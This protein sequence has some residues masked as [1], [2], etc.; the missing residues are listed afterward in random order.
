[1]RKRLLP[2]L[3][4]AA[5]LAAPAAAE[6]LGKH[7]QLTPFG[8]WTWLDGDIRFASGAPLT[9]DL[10][11]GGRIGYAFHPLLTAE[12][13]GG[14]TPTA[15]DVTG[16][17][18]VDFTHASANLVLTPWNTRRGGPIVFGGVGLARTKITGGE[19]EGGLG[20][21]YG[22]GARLWLSDAVG[23][24][25]E[26]RTVYSKA[27]P[28]G[29]GTIHLNDVVAGGG[30]TF[31]LGATPRDTDGDGVPD[32]RDRCPDTPR[33]ARVDAAGCPIDSD[34]DKVFDGLDQCEGTP[35]GATVDAKGCPSDSDGDKVWDGID[36][37]ADTPAGASVDARGCPNDPDGDGV[38]DGIDQC[39]DTPR[40]C[41]VDEKGCPKDADGD[42]VCDGRDQCPDTSPGLKVDEKGCPMEL[43]ERETELLD[44]GM[45]RFNNIRFATN[46]AELDSTSLPTLDLV[47]TI[48][49]KWPELRIEIGGHTDARGSDAHNRQLSER[50]AESVRSYLV[51]KFPGLNAA[52]Y[53]ANGY[54]EARPVVPN[55]DEATWALNRRVEFVVLNKDVLKREIE[56]R[57]LLPKTEAAP[58]D[59]TQR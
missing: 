46:S 27:E 38:V 5:L 2:A 45:M 3:A 43:I 10:Y 19:S 13:A 36:Q 33:G 34:G 42:G 55:R 44:T 49:T 24:R 12:A 16:G 9:D 58:P 15:E 18:N 23:L 6:P 37:C 41:P 47:G 22:A 25:L 51:T 32:K 4:A 52:Q 26:V 8:G 31:A 20:L 54:G 48:L 29:G 39:P 50:R 56:R 11:F 40:D 1:V 28:A 17:R 7:F 30:I 35:A 59:T 53:T 14:V 57:R 21:E